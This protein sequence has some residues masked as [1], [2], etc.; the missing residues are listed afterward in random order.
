MSLLTWGPVRTLRKS[1]IEV[2]RLPRRVPR[3]RYLV[4]HP[5][6]ASARGRLIR[7]V[8]LG[9]LVRATNRRLR[10]HDP[11]QVDIDQLLLGDSPDVSMPNF[12]WMIDDLGYSSTPVERWPHTELLRDF[13]RDGEAVFAPERFAASSYARHCMR[14][15]DL[16]GDFQGTT[17]PAQLVDVGRDFV[18]R[19]GGA[20]TPRRRHQSGEG[21]VLVRE[22]KWS[23]KYQVVD[24]HHRVAIAHTQGD[25]TIEVLP[26]RRKTLT[27]LQEHLLAMSWTEGIHQRYQ[28]IDAPE[29]ATWPVVRRCEDRFAMMQ[30]FL[31][32]RGLLGATPGS[33]LDLAACYGWFV[34]AFAGLGFD[35]HGNEIDP[36]SA[37][38]AHDINGVPTSHWHVDELTKYLRGLEQPFTVVS[39]LSLLHNYILDGGVDSPEGLMRLLD[40]AT[41][42]VLFFDTG[43]AHEFW[44]RR[45]LQKWSPAYIHQWLRENT[46]FDEIIALGTD[47]DAVPPF[48]DN[49]GRTLFALV[50]N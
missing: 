31:G 20:S 23:D 44:F 8:L 47:E 34:R 3:I 12:G 10:T 13:A 19:A 42:K 17:D 21:P 6:P 27:A 50:R 43:E 48:A 32:D 38:L 37:R 25:T 36:L 33:Y 24:G 18:A 11:R 39:C 45:T 9:H 28:P 16:V 1:V 7:R 26:A 4:M 30:R 46:T 41:A 15:I 2:R 5:D 29:L 22:I 49:F 14:F 35:A 40:A